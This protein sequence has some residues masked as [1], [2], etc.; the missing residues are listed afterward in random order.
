VPPRQQAVLVLGTATEPRIL[1]DAGVTR[2]PKY[3][4]GPEYQMTGFSDD[5]LTAAGHMTGVGDIENQPL[6]WRCRIT[7]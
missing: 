1:S 6:V 3:R 4:N 7:S 2:L 5:G